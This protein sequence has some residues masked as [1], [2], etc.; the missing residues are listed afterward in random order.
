MTKIF[1]LDQIK[2][3]INKINLI[4]LIETGFVEYSKGNVVIPPVG[5][6]IFENPPGDVHIKYGY[7]KNDD[8]F[9]I[10]IASGFPNNYELGINNL[11]GLMLVFDQKTA[12]PLAILLDEGYL[13]EVRTG[14]AGAI[15]AKYFAPKVTRIGIVGTG[16]QARYQL[17]F[18]KKVTNC[19]EA[20]VWGRNQTKL[21]VFKNDME[22]NYKIETTTDMRNITNNCNLIITT[23][24]AS[25]SLIEA[26]MVLP[27]THITA[28]GSDTSHKRELDP[29]I[30]GKANKVIV[31]SKSQSRLR[32]EVSHALKND[33]IKDTNLIEL[34]SVISKPILGRENDKEITIVDLTGVAVQDIQIAKAVYLKLVN[35]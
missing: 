25:Q 30:L 19:R 16:G 9:V 5:E 31:D 17:E 28:I 26:E 35:K 32:G 4:S 34:G 3:V 8:F 18:L 13:S 6:M 33:I 21:D 1:K 2:S 14:I 23:T 15:S 27:G 12:Q 20:I 11:Q 29:R 7:I 22:I 10:K 24:S